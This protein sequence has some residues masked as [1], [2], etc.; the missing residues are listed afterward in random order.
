MP[1]F[2]EMPFEHMLFTPL[3]ARVASMYMGMN[4]IA[5]HRASWHQHNRGLQ[6]L[7]VL[8]SKKTFEGRNMEGSVLWIL[9]WGSGEMGGFLLQSVG[10]AHPGLLQ[11][12]GGWL[13]L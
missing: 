13:S 8:V 6:C 1:G 9:L 3:P 10:P 12:G 7:P 2:S 5:C 11:P 4:H